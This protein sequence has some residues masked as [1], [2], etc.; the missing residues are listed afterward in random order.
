MTVKLLTWTRLLALAALSG[1]WFSIWNCL[2]DALIDTAA[3][4][5]TWL[6]WL[7]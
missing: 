5:V 3:G 6:A 1:L 7:Q 2:I 4:H